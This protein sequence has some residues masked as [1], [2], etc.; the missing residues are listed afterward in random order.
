MPAEAD[1]V[2]DV[3]DAAV[4]YQ[5]PEAYMIGTVL[6]GL[7]F[8]FIIAAKKYKKS[9]NDH[10]KAKGL[11]KEECPFGGDFLASIIVSAAF[12]AFAA[13]IGS[14][15]L[16]GLAG[17]Q[18]APAMVYYFMA[19]LIGLVSGRYAGSFLSD[20]CDIVRDKLKIVGAVSSGAESGVD[21]AAA[22]AQKAVKKEE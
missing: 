10:L 2:D 12:G 22:S 9:Y 14:G 8:A 20:I 3:I 6:I 11:T 1:F 13:Y 4:S 16:L 21:T 17:H 15:I 19:F 7:L 5:T 18:D